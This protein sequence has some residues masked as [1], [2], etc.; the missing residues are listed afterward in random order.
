[1]G[2]LKYSACKKSLPKARDNHS[3]GKVAAIPFI[4]VLLFIFLHLKHKEEGVKT[5]S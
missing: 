4:N 3:E 5:P 1:M 2:S